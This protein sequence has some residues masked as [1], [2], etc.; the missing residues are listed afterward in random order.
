MDF[1][2]VIPAYNG[3]GT[4]AE[5]IQTILTQSHPAREVIVVDDGSTDGTRDVLAG[6]GAQIVF[7]TQ[8]NAGVQA[9]RNLAASRSTADWIAFCDQDDLWQPTYLAAQ[10]ALLT[11]A[12]EVGF[13]FSNF[14]VL[15]NDVL[16]SRTKFDDAPPGWWDSL[17]PRKLP[18]GMVFPNSIASATYRFHPVFPSAMAVSKTLL[19]SIGGFDTAMRGLRNEDGELVLR[20]LYRGT[21][22]ALTDPHVT[23]RRHAGNFSR[24]IIARLLDEIVTMNFIKENHVDARP[25]HGIID[26]EIRLKYI[27]LVNLTFAARDHARL[28]EMF[29]HV[30]WDD[31]DVKMWVKRAVAALPDPIGL[32]LNTA[33]QK[34]IGGKVADESVLTR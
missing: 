12:P 31:R 9:A 19:A 21:A 24:D 26:D 27:D 20:C 33:L 29:R 34:H 15:R 5:T 10:S 16:D 6:F 32:K 13:S 23:I 7:L 2:V 17:N 18:Q 14:R 8:A 22:G 28:R 4:I 30:S 1:S 11:A 25:Y 3:Q